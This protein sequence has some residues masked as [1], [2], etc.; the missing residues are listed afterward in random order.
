[1][2]KRCWDAQIGNSSQILCTND[3][4]AKRK[5]VKKKVETHLEG[6]SS[7]IIDGKQ[8]RQ[9]NPDDVQYGMQTGRIKKV[10]CTRRRLSKECS[11]IEIDGNSIQLCKD[12]PLAK[13]LDVE[14][15]VDF[16]LTGCKEAQFRT[17]YGTFNMNESKGGMDS[18]KR[19]SIARQVSKGEITGVRCIKKI[20]SR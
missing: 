3:T 5:I 11:N 6:C 18:K 14:D 16:T 20:R 17:G 7:A 19:H 8:H 9:I 13:K 10:K 2:R 4:I 1:M 12:D 15:A